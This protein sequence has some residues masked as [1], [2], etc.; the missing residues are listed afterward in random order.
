MDKARPPFQTRMNQ[1]SLGIPGNRCDTILF[2][3]RRKQYETYCR[4]DAYL[5]SPDRP[6]VRR[7]LCSPEGQV[8][9]VTDPTVPSPQTGVSGSLLM[10]A[11][12]MIGCLGAAVAAF[13]KSSVR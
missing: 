8:E 9:I 10:A 12:G 6:F 11:V 3:E 5:H 2:C 4:M 7:G 13:R 1:Q